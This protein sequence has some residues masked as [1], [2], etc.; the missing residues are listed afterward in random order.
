MVDSKTG[1][2]LGYTWSYIRIVY[3]KNNLRFIHDKIYEKSNWIYIQVDDG[4]ALVSLKQLS[5]DLYGNTIN[6]HDLA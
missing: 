3:D 6:K 5:L 1:S 4:I 2:C